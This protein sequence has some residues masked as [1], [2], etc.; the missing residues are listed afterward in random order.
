MFV[1]FTMC[2][3]CVCSIFTY[4][5]KEINQANAILKDE[6]KKKI[7]DDYGHYG[8]KLAEQVGEEVSIVCVCVYCVV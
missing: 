3:T 6:K 5:F 8:L 4:Q 2:V 1:Q 7:Y